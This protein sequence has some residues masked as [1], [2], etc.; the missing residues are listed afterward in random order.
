MNE[1]ILSSVTDTPSFNINLLKRQMKT[2]G[3]GLFWLMISAQ[4]LAVIPLLI[5]SSLA[6]IGVIDTTL[7]TWLATDIGIYGIGLPLFYM[8]IKRIPKSKIKD[9]HYKFNLKKVIYTSFVLFGILYTFN[10]LALGITEILQIITGREIV[11]FLEDTINS[12]TS[13]Y[14]FVFVVIIGPILEE[15]LFR[16]MI[17]ERTLILGETFAIVFSGLTFGLFHGNLNQT[18]YATMLGIALAYIYIKCGNLKYPIFFHMIVNLLGSFLMPLLLSKNESESIFVTIFVI[19]TILIAAYTFIKYHKS[20][21]LDEGNIPLS[22]KEKFKLGMLT[23]G[24]IIYTVTFI[25]LIIIILFFL[26]QE[27]DLIN[28]KSSLNK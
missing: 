25:L 12:T 19:F 3:W 11:N 28:I 18:I 10:L 23:P 6:E 13:I 2:M 20:I 21:D 7:A 26:Y 24:Y 16:K 9:K 22:T 17:I 15:I 5:F 8:V 1:E 27:I 4:F 14:T